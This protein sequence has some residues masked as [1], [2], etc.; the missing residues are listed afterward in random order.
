MR[1]H[2][3]LLVLLMAPL[4]GADWH[5]VADGGDDE[6]GSGAPEAPFA[7]IAHAVAQAAA[8]DVVRL[9]P[10]THRM[11]ATIDLPQGV[12]IVGAGRFGPTPTI[13]TNTWTDSFPDGGWNEIGYLF[14]IKNAGGNRLADFIVDGRADSLRSAILVRWSEDVVIEDI[15]FRELSWS[16]IWVWSHQ[17]ADFTPGRENYSTDIHIRRCRVVDCG[18]DGNGY[19]QAAINLHGVSGGSITD[20]VVYNF[21]ENVGYCLG[22]GEVEDITVARNILAIKV[23]S[24][25]NNGLSD[26]F[27]LTGGSMTRVDIHDNLLNQTI[28]IT[29]HGKPDHRAEPYTFRF[30]H[31]LVDFYTGYF[32]LTQHD[33][34]IDHNIF[35]GPGNGYGFL[36]QYGTAAGSVNDL[37]IHHNLLQYC[38]GI[39][40]ARD[41]KPS[42][43]RTSK[44]FRNL[45]IINNTLHL[46]MMN[47]WQSSTL[48]DYPYDVAGHEIALH[49]NV[50]LQREEGGSHSILAIEGTDGGV[51]MQASHQ[52]STVYDSLP[53]SDNL[54]QDPA[55]ALRGTDWEAWYRPD[56]A[57][58]A[59]ASGL[60]IDG[61]TGAAPNRGAFQDSDADADVVGPRVAAWRRPLL[62]A[63]SMPT[64]A[65][66]TW[67]YWDY[68]SDDKPAYRASPDSPHGVLHCVPLLDRTPDATGTA[69]APDIGIGADLDGDNQ[70]FGMLF[71]GLLEVPVT[72]TYHFR[73]AGR[74]QVR[75]QIHDPDRDPLWHGGWRDVVEKVGFSVD[76]VVQDRIDLEAGLHRVR[77]WSA[78][79]WD[80]R[81]PGPFSLE[82]LPPGGNAFV[83]IPEERW[84]RPD[85]DV[86][87]RRIRIG[88][89]RQARLVPVQ[90]SSAPD[91]RYDE[92]V[93]G[94]G[95]YA[96]DGFD[97]STQQTISLLTDG[98]G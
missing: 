30:H 17:A 63:T 92:Q 33:V 44:A 53:G 23:R 2:I 27:S 9:G 95:W 74:D 56:A 52:L 58:P 11:D 10:G 88:V 72:G 7:T 76:P 22:M 18:W 28:S 32:E 41:G 54:Q 64:R 24:L 36:A 19:S 97:A 34:I 68:A 51:T 66:L 82:W 15:T 59:H 13:I 57:S 8:G 70:L 48:V 86:D 91:V 80:G 85:P 35:T 38:T 71:E 46:P 31:N 79:L 78:L 42:D 43:G 75:F 96:L 77:I 16:A 98:D 61:I 12:D 90:V 40:S 73:M 25:W 50:I 65:G 20:C 26:H 39:V 45:R 89:F 62:R 81:A 4:W 84:S 67:R 60:G 6:T 83:A 47:G 1:Y 49:N 94:Q 69:A 29:P 3:C 14:K 93:D 55:L 87:Q 21:A 37:L 5:V